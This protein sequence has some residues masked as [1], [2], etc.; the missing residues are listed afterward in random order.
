[1]NIQI[2]SPW[3]PFH[4]SVM[5]ASGEKCYAHFLVWQLASI[6]LIWET[7]SVLHK[8]GNAGLSS[9]NLAFQRHRVTWLT[10]TIYRDAKIC[11]CPG[12]K[13]L[14]KN[15]MT[16][17]CTLLGIEKSA[18]AI[19]HPSPYFAVHIK[20]LC[21]DAV[22]SFLWT[23]CSVIARHFFALCVIDLK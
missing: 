17:V 13:C 6:F 21:W 8:S 1:M 5:W 20:Y 3:L 15:L 19:N 18:K 23:W 2:N 9:P 12:F 4:V 14:W 16:I 7:S 22:F 10:L 11:P